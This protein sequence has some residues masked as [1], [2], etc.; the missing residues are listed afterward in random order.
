MAD[1][2]IIAS[3][4]TTL[5]VPLKRI[6]DGADKAGLTEAIVIGHDENGELYVAATHNEL[7]IN[8]VLVER[9]KQIL[10]GQVEQ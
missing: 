6:L 4:P 8:L 3:I 5:P 7:G 2:V 1:N 9:A 10:L